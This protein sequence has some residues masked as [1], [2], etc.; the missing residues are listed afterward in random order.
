MVNHVSNKNKMKNNIYFEYFLK[1]WLSVFFLFF[2][3]IGVWV[4]LKSW[5]MLENETTQKTWEPNLGM[6]GSLF[7]A[8]RGI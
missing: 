5:E 2:L 3:S 1:A 6:G 4:P 7:P 8:F